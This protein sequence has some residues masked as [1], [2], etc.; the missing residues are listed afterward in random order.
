MANI[1]LRTYEKQIEEMID[2]GRLQEA[3]AHCKHIIKAYPKC[4]SSYRILGK[5]FLEGKQY[6]ETADIFKRVLTVYPDDFISHVGMS[7]VRENE[8]NL[9]AAIWHMELAFDSQPSNIT[10]Q[11]ELKR[12]FGRRDG[13]HPAKIRLT[14]GALVRMYA[15]G[16][17]YQ[18]AIAEIKSAVTED[19]KRQDLEVFLAKMYYLSGEQSEAIEL[20]KKLV[21]E[22][23]YCFE[24]N[25]ILSETLPAVNPNEKVSVYTDRLRELDP[26]QS[27]VNPKFPAAE[28][29]PDDKVV[30]NEL[31][32]LP[33]P[34]PARDS[35]WVSSLENEWEKPASPFAQEETSFINDIPVPSET[36][37]IQA[38]NGDAL[39]S[40]AEPV[41][42][43]FAQTD[44]TKSESASPEWT[45]PEDW[46]PTVEE[47]QQMDSSPL[48]NTTS[49]EQQPQDVPDWLRSLVPE[50]S[51]SDSVALTEPVDQPQSALLDFSQELDNDSPVKNDSINEPV[52]TN[53]APK[54]EPTGS[55]SDT[56][57]PDWLKNF[58]TEE[59]SEPVTQDDLPDWLNSLQNTSI[60]PT[61]DESMTPAFE[62]PL[63]GLL[64]SQMNESTVPIEETDSAQMDAEKE[65]IK[66]Q[67]FA[68]FE[69]EPSATSQVGEIE[70]VP[71]VSGQTEI[72]D[73]IRMLHNET[74]EEGKPDNELSAEANSKDESPVSS[75][76]MENNADIVDDPNSTISEKTSDELLEWLRD[77]KPEEGVNSQNEL[78]NPLESATGNTDSLNYDFDAELQKLSQLEPNVTEEPQPTST[79]EVDQDSEID[80]STDLLSRLQEKSAPAEE[81][82]LPN[83]DL[84][85]EKSSEQIGNDLDSLLK[86]FS[87]NESPVAEKEEI[88]D[89]TAAEVLPAIEAPAS[90]APV[91]QTLDELIRLSQENPDDYLNWQQLGDAYAKSSQYSNALSAYNKAEQILIIR[92]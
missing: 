88:T 33:T 63:G 8:N 11:E 74:P 16:E 78:E 38:Q 77:L 42:D 32:N 20:C 1:P 50:G 21:Q 10:I 44:E 71:A 26:Y 66:E 14:R 49:S 61:A 51:P 86:D 29:V 69:Q 19:T 68:A 24:V 4:I 2:Q 72:P 35:A 17:L 47:P 57:L 54:K 3:V 76:I 34:E 9:D 90:T 39:L 87:F 27:Y 46:L 13:T 80:D 40:T 91:G 7:I 81:Y 30:V 43:P 58:D 6:N 84:P 28:D 70:E 37:P 67:P 25:K 12:L 83:F 18:Q 79:S 52:I 23:P 82:Q 92:K 59:P 85:E 56:S 62:S 75:L 22:L 64:A 31:A 65:E 55:L 60:K 53:P 48:Q 5:A 89:N 73:W 36:Q 41:F 15:R 45:K